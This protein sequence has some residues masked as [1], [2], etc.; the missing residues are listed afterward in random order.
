MISLNQHLVASNIGISVAHMKLPS[1]RFERAITAM[2]SCYPNGGIKREELDRICGC[3]NSPDIIL[4]LRRDYVG[5]DGVNCKMVD[6]IDRDGRRC[7]AGMYSFS[8]AGFTR[9]HELGLYRG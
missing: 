3:S 2:V 4:K 8:E 5:F 9:I 7:K 6:C 1:A